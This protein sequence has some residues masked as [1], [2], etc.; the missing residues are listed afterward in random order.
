MHFSQL[1]VLTRA[2]LGFFRH[3]GCIL[4]AMFDCFFEYAFWSVWKAC[5]AQ[6]PS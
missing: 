4:I 5:A 3:Q 6:I 2:A 1:Y